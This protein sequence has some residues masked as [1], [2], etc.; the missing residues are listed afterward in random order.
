MGRLDK[1]SKQEIQRRKLQFKRDS[2]KE[3]LQ[4]R[5]SQTSRRIGQ[6]AI[7]DQKPRFEGGCD[8]RGT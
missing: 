8:L 5:V 1:K 2:K 7:L 3:V 6:T 4:T